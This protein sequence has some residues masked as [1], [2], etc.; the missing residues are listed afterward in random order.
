MTA[1]D[2]AR[3]RQTDIEIAE[4]AT[5]RERARPDLEVIHFLCGIAAADDGADGRANDHIGNNAMRFKSTDYAYMGESASSAA[6]K[7]QAN[8]WAH[9]DGLRMRRGF[10]RT[11]AVAGSRE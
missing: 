1:A 10:R 3:A 7:C 2:Q 5:H 9:R 4:H 11:V 6:A 8:G